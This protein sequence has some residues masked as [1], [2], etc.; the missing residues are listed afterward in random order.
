MNSNAIRLSLAFS[1][2]CPVREGNV[3]IFGD[4]ELHLNRMF[5]TVNKAFGAMYQ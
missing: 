4:G 3:T 5:K 2:Q 1:I